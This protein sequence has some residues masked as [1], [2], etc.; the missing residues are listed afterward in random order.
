MKTLIKEAAAEQDVT[1]LKIL[2]KYERRK[3]LVL[4]K[5]Q[6]QLQKYVHSNPAYKGLLNMISDI[7]SKQRLGEGFWSAA[8]DK[9]SQYRD[10]W[11][12]YQ[13]RNYASAFRKE[14]SKMIEE[15]GEDFGLPKSENVIV[16]LVKDNAIK[17][18]PLR[19]EVIQ[20]VVESIKMY[21]T[22]IETLDQI[23][24]VQK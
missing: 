16:Q 14:Y 24:T 21:F 20:K 7:I 19:P 17:D 6:E 11:K 15:I 3:M 23:D 12:D 1:M 5:L 22:L 18:R 9:L 8:K 2:N 4:S 10:K 13:V